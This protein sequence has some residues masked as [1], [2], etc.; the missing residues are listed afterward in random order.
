MW[1]PPTEYTL[2]RSHDVILGAPWFARYNPDIDWITHE[3]HVAEPDVDYGKLNAFID[4]VTSEDLGV[5]IDR[6]EAAFEGR[7]V[8]IVSSVK[9]E[10]Q[11]PAMP[12]SAGIA[13]VLKEYDDCAPHVLP[14]KLPPH[15]EVEFELTMKPDATPSSRAPFRLSKTEQEALDGFV[16]EMLESNWIEVSESPWVSSIFAVPK[17]DPAFGKQPSRSEWIKPGN[18][19]HPVRW[20][21]HYRY[22]NSQTEIPNIPLPRIEKIFDR[23]PGCT[24]FSTLGLAQGYHK[25]LAVPSSKKFTA[26]RTDKEV[27]QLRVAPMGLSGMSRVWSRLMRVLFVKFTL[28][29]STWMI[30]ACSH[31]A[32]KSTVS[33]CARCSRCSGVSGCTS[34]WRSVHLDGHVSASWVI[35]SPL[36]GCM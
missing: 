10:E 16:Q 23:M 28:L 14:N 32:R 3:V 25:M 4:E 18:A 8:E 6:L 9:V 33:I 15:C 31:A 13:E 5:P 7:S 29:S 26:F 36:T 35:Q 2:P 17:K 11:R 20:V 34:A 27:Y 12:V 22:V 21:V 19:Q 1:L 30:C 24:I